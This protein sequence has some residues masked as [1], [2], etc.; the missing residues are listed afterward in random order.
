[1]LE[2]RLCVD[3]TAAAPGARPRRLPA[4]VVGRQRRSAD[5][6][7]GWK[8]GGP[9]RGFV[10]TV[11]SGRRGNRHTANVE[12]AVV[13]L[14]AFVAAPAIADEVRVSRRVLFGARETGGVVVGRFNEQ[15]LAVWTDCR[16]HVDVERL[17]FSPTRIT[18]RA[19]LLFGEAA[20]AGRA[21]RQLV[22]GTVDRQVGCRIRIV[23]RVYDC[24]GF[25][26]AVTRAVLCQTVRRLEVG[27]RVS[28]RRIRTDRP[29][30]VGTDQRQTLRVPG[31]SVGTD[32][33]G[34]SGA[35]P[36]SEIRSAG[37]RRLLC[38]GHARLLRRVSEGHGVHRTAAR[39]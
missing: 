9:L 2:A 19:E 33:F 5:G 20:V 10:I 28:G 30:N 35:R 39:R 1:M 16:N 31:G 15:N 18:L 24:D 3:L 23:E 38:Q 8:N 17:L 29:V 13:R 22:G 34:L 11:V 7:Y 37:M 21:R 36:K 12:V 6:D 25:A 32:P 27:R 26:A 14:R 4:R